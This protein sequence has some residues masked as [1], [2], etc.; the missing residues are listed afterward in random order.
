M[1]SML[2]HDGAALVIANMNYQGLGMDKNCT[3]ALSYYLSVVKKS[4]VDFY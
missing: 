1:S 4:Y 3:T 2:G